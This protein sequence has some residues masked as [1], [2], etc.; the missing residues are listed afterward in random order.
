M[1]SMERTIIVV[2]IIIITGVIRKPTFSHEFVLCSILLVVS[3]SL[4]GAARRMFVEREGDELVCV[5]SKPLFLS[6]SVGPL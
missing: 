4:R 5:V 1:E 2:I 3:S 6:L